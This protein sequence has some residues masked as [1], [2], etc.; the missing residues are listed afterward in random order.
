[1]TVESILLPILM[2]IGG[3]LVR[4]VDLFGQ[5]GGGASPTAAPVPAAHPILTALA[6][7]L[8]EYQLRSGTNVNMRNPPPVPPA[9]SVTSANG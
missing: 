7:L 2:A 4:H 5:G 1:M 8:A 9:P 3:Y 6:G